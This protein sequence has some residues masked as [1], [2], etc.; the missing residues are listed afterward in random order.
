M[1]GRPSK[2]Q[3]AKAQADLRNKEAVL[4][5]QYYSNNR[6]RSIE[7]QIQRERQLYLKQHGNTPAVTVGGQARAP[8]GTVAPGSPGALPSTP[9]ASATVRAREA[10]AVTAARVTAPV[11][12]GPRAPAATPAAPAGA[13]P[14]RGAP[15]GVTMVKESRPAPPPG[16]GIQLVDPQTGKPLPQSPGRAPLAAQ[17]KGAWPT[18]P[19]GY[20]QQYGAQYGQQQ[21][22]WGQGGRGAP[23]QQFQIGAPHSQYALAPAAPPPAPAARPDR[24]F[25][26]SGEALAPF[27]AATLD[28]ARLRWEYSSVLPPRPRPRAPVPASPGP[29]SAPRRPETAP[30]AP[31]PPSGDHSAARRGPAPAPAATSAPSA[32]VLQPAPLT[33]ASSSPSTPAP[34]APAAAAGVGAPAA[35]AGPAPASSLVLPLLEQ[36]SPF[37]L[38]FDRQ[39]P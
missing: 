36:A 8:H 32:M 27:L 24:V 33:A 29:L 13:Q 30:A 3:F 9:P 26:P 37:A 31:V 18:S 25:V 5:D 11:P 6:L 15:V 2:P 10:P 22:A 34:A 7:S 20:G 12:A 17:A 14:A 21:G 39:I 19:G 16:R 38:T 4:Y 1:F 23:P 35:A 28:P